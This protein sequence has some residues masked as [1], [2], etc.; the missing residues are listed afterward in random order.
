V[1]AVL[2]QLPTPE[3]IRLDHKDRH[4]GSRGVRLNPPHHRHPLPSPSRSLRSPPLVRA[5]TQKSQERTVDHPGKSQSV[6]LSPLRNQ[7]GD[8]L[9]LLPDEGPG[10]RRQVPSDCQASR[11]G[12]PRAEIPALS[13]LHGVRL[14]RD[15][16][17]DGDARG[18]SG[19]IEENPKKA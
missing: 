4:L 15:Q 19:S 5:G 2:S 6:V 8:S 7:H 11:Q 18:Q 1:E 12:S 3:D 10:N 17:F 14:C 13:D 16:L 9:T